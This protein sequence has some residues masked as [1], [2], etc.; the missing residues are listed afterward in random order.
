M[1]HH[2][3]L[4]VP[5]EHTAA[6]ADALLAVYSARAYA[7]AE[8]AE[9]TDAEKLQ[10][11]RSALADAEAALDVFGWQRAP[12]L[13]AAE[14]TGTSGLLAEVLSCAVVDASQSFEAVF[15]EYGRAQAAL[16]EVEAAGRQLAALLRLFAA[17]EREQA[18]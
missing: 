5:A 18:V 16:S 4:T 17:F 2:A 12:R 13:E 6:V 1:P 8:Y 15:G 9:R 14:L 3:H 10:D 11:C 7:V